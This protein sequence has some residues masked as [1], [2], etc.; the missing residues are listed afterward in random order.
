MKIAITGGSGGIGRATIVRALSEGHRVTNIDRAPPPADHPAADAPFVQLDVTDYAAFAA[1]LVG[2]DALIHLGAIPSPGSHPDHVVH[3]NNVVGSYNALLAAVNSGIKRVC[4]A[5]SINA[6]GSSY[7]RA[8][9]FDYFPLDE[10]HPTYN[11][12]PY[13]LSKWICELQAD[14]IARRYDD[15]AIASLRFHWVID[16]ETASHYRGGDDQRGARGLWAYTSVPAAVD[17]CL[18]GVS[19]DF[20]GHHVFYIVA[21]QTVT[22]TSSRE[23]ATQ[24]YPD[25]PIRGEFAGNHGFYDCSRA[26]QVL[27]WRHED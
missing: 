4:Q 17:A 20:R 26:E 3:N 7:S 25:T 1:A 19:A 2:H 9:R 27:G 22:P 15:M 21:P 13:S 5:S 16:R 11:E 8:P 6:I 18:R 10:A 14:S 23:I 12:D 24:Y